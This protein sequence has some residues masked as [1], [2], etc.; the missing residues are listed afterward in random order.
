[1]WPGAPGV[2]DCVIQFVHSFASVLQG[3]TTKPGI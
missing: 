2:V 3:L 1:M